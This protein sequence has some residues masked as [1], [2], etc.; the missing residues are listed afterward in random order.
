MIRRPASGLGGDPTESKLSQIEFVDKDVDDANRIVLADPVFQAVRKQRAL[1][2]IRTST[3]RLI[4]SSRKSHGN[5]IARIKS[6]DAFLHR[7]A[8]R[9]ARSRWCKST[10]MKE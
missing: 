6:S 8:G 10:T 5:R 3:K 2:A 9:P 1:P 4:R 7:C